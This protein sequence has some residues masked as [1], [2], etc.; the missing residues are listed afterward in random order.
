[1]KRAEEKQRS[2]EGQGSTWDPDEL[3]CQRGGGRWGTLEDTRGPQGLSLKTFLPHTPP[4]P[5]VR[6]WWDV[7]EPEG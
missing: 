3:D 2:G 1:M 5:C 7:T 4:L 6:W